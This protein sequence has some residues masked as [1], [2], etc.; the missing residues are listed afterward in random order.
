MP[1]LSFEPFKRHPIGRIR[2][3]Q[4]CDSFEILGWPVSGID[5]SEASFSIGNPVKFRIQSLE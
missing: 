5:L 2:L 3:S 1:I 4:R